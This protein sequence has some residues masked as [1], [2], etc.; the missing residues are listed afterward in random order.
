[1]AYGQV[2]EFAGFQQGM[3]GDS[4]SAR[5]GRSSALESDALSEFQAPCVQAAFGIATR[6]D[7]DGRLVEQPSQVFVPTPGDV[8]VIIDFPRLEAAGREAQ[9][10]RDG[11]RPAEASGSSMAAMNEVAVTTPMPGSSS[12]H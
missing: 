9:P 3:H 10:S 8:A 7:D 5:Q 6:R 11:A 2:E 12:L 4:Q 1:M